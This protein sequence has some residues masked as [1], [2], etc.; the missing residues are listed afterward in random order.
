MIEYEENETYDPFYSSAMSEDPS[1][2]GDY[3]D[4]QQP[5]KIYRRKSNKYHKLIYAPENKRILAEECPRC[6]LKDSSGCYAVFQS[7]KSF[8]RCAKRSTKSEHVYI[9]VPVG[10]RPGLKGKQFG[11]LLVIDKAGRNKHHHQLWRCRCDC[12]RE[13]IVSQQNLRSGNTKSC[14]CGQFKRGTIYKGEEARMDES[15]S[16]EKPESREAKWTN[17]LKGNKIIDDRGNNV[18]EEST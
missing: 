14:G 4:H 11:K 16:S 17:F 6:S 1:T 8:M 12:G 15:D 9:Y 2:L 18:Y 7:G 5:F 13:T 3:D 10:P